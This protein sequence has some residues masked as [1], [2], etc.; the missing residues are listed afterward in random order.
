MTDWR[1]KILNEF[2]PGLGKTIMVADPDRLLTEPR[3]SEALSAKGFELLLYED[4][5]Q[6][7]FV[8]ETRYRPFFVTGNATDLIIF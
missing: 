2:T 6:L 1:D 5:V 3:L 4:P 8:Y 7:R